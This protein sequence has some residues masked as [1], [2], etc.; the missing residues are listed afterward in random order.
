[1]CDG[2]IYTKWLWVDEFN[3]YTL[4][5]TKYYVEAIT[6]ILSHEWKKENFDKSWMLSL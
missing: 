6:Q 2:P 1:M 3:N 4:L 5:L